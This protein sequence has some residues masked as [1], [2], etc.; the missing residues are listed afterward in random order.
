MSSAKIVTQSCAI[1]ERERRQS[2]RSISTSSLDLGVTTAAKLNNLLNNKYRDLPVMKTDDFC[3]KVCIA[4]IA[5]VR[6]LSRKLQNVAGTSACF[7]T[8]R[9]VDDT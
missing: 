8:L 4:Y 9:Y 2:L 7:A 1:C 3:T 5:F 6:R